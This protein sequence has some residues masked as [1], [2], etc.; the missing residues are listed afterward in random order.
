MDG[1]I[2]A[3]N[4]VRV[5][6]LNANM[7]HASFLV[8]GQK[9]VDGAGGTQRLQQLLYLTQSYGG[10][11]S[12][13]QIKPQFWYCRGWRIQWTRRVLGGPGQYENWWTRSNMKLAALCAKNIA[14]E[15]HALFWQDQFIPKEYQKRKHYEPMLGTAMAT[16]LSLPRRSR[17]DAAV[18]KARATLPREAMYAMTQTGFHSFTFQ[19]DDIETILIM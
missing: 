1:R 6:Y 15:S 2:R 12:K 16:W 11:C 14:V 18:P 13:D 5:W 19:T 17:G 9:V 8:L 10:S 3:K 4:G 7:V